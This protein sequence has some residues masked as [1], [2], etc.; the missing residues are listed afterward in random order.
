M[1][2]VLAIDSAMTTRF[3]VPLNTSAEQHIRLSTLQTVFSQA[4]NALTPL[5]RESHCWNRVGLHHLAYRRLREQFPAL[6]SQM[7]CNV[8]YS[9]SRACRY[10]YQNPESPWLATRETNTELPLVL[11][12]SH[13]PVYFDRHT[14]SLRDGGVSMFTLDGRMRFQ[15]H[16]SEKQQMHFFN[17]RLLVVML[18]QIEGVFHLCFAFAEGDAQESPEPMGTNLP[19]YLVVREHAVESE[20]TVL[21]LDIKTR[22]TGAA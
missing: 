3:N 5:V 13:A 18:R 15:V 8:I 7:V 16:I 4:C 1:L 19:E 9:V 2:N 17:D 20:T 12:G 21:P 14:L 22:L 11:F 6:G 10:V